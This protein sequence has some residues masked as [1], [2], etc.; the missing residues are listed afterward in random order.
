MS[1]WIWWIGLPLSFV[2]AIVAIQ[3]LRIAAIMIS[4]WKSNR[5]YW[6]SQLRLRAASFLEP[7]ENVASDLKE[8]EQQVRIRCS[9]RQ[10][11][12]PEKLEGLYSWLEILMANLL[13]KI[14][15]GR[16]GLSCRTP[17]TFTKLSLLL[18]RNFT[19]LSCR[20]GET[21]PGIETRMLII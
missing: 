1:W 15:L 19:I 3:C 10:S 16:C 12:R 6:I 20:I 7:P 9:T 4:I 14:T 8:A 13:T 21:I 17:A 11:E 18:V 2:A 5:Y